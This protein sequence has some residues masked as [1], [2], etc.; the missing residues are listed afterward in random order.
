M[1]PE[2]STKTNDHLSPPPW[3]AKWAGQAAP[4]PGHFS[5]AALA[6][7]RLRYLEDLFKIGNARRGE[8]VQYSAKR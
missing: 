4:I 3:P 7:R 2:N 8:G 5:I 1:I 6:S